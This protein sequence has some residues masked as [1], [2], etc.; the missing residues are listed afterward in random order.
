MKR[1]I[2]HISTAVVFVL[3]FVSCDSL[4]NVAP[5]T[6]P[7]NP[8]V[9]QVT[10]NA[11]KSEIQSLVTGLEVRNRQ[12]AGSRIELLGSFGREVWI[13][14]FIDGRFMTEWLG[15]SGNAEEN[16]SFFADG[17]VYSTPYTAIRQANL[18]LK[19]VENTDNLSEQEKEG[20]RGFAKTIKGYQFLIP[21][22]AQYENGIRVDVSDPNNLGPF[23]SYDEALSEIRAMLD[24][25]YQHLQNAGDNFFFALSEGLS[26]FSN[27][28]AMAQLNRA[29]AARAAVYAEDWQG[30]LDALADAEPFFELAAGEAVMNKGAYFSYGEPPGMFNP[31]FWPRNSVPDHI[32]VVHPSVIEDTLAGDLRID[33]KFFLRDTPLNNPNAPVPVHYQGNRFATTQSPIPMIRNEELILIYAEAKTQLGGAANL[34][35][36]VDAINLIRNTWNLADYSGSVTQTALI[37][38][39]LLQRRYS[40]WAEW[41]HRWIDMRRYGRLDEIAQ[42]DMLVGTIFTQFARPE[43]EQG[44]N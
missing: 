25:G 7:N 13:F 30:A 42:N 44:Q 31:L 3:F 29:I 18:L 8:S 37:D 32:M 5:V 20:V 17:S 2:Y 19:V 33:R 22:L 6:D 39:I 23:L 43:S 35:D 36:A 14:D 28:A 16:P 11:T 40:L 4:L 21:L 34:S 15:I 9:E 41:G 26:N 10:Q 24:S 27:P 38:E 12:G 1:S